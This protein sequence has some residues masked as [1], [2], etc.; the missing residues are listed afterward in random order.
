MASKSIRF[1]AE[2]LDSPLTVPEL[3]G[4]LLPLATPPVS[5]PSVRAAAEPADVEIMMATVSVSVFSVAGSSA[6]AMQGRVVFNQACKAMVG[7]FSGASAPGD[8]ALF[9]TSHPDIGIRL[10]YIGKPILPE[11][12]QSFPLVGDMLVF[13]AMLVA[14]H[15]QVK[16]GAVEA[17]IAFNYG[18]DW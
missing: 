14:L 9:A 17:R 8:E 3:G 12:G 4:G 5:E 10:S 1:S 6:A 7:Y 15:D 13:E 2:V 18:S 11:Q 16:P